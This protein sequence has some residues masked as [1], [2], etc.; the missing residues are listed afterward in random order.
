MFFTPVVLNCI[1]LAVW[2]NEHGTEILTSAAAGTAAVMACGLVILLYA[3]VKKFR[4]GLRG[5]E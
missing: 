4:A 3:A 2:G 1:I 5:G